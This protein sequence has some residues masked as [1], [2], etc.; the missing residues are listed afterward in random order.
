LVLQRDEFA[1]PETGEEEDAQG[2]AVDQ[3][4][5][6][7]RSVGQRIARQQ[8]AAGLLAGQD[9]GRRSPPP[10]AEKPW[11]RHEGPWLLK[12][13]KPREGSNHGE[14]VR[15][16]AIRFPGQVRP[17]DGLREYVI[18]PADR[19]SLELGE[20]ALFPVIR[21]AERV[22]VLEQAG[23]VRSERTCGDGHRHTS[24]SDKATERKPVRSTCA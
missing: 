6:K 10:D 11:R 17:H 23:D 13:E 14:T 7:R 21:D 24:A 20:K 18:G 1:P 4:P 3:S 19:G 22:F 15:A 9:P 5:R 16:T 2:G 12:D 8:K